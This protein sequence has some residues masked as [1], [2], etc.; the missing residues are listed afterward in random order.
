MDP[1]AALV[2]GAL[3]AFASTSVTGLIQW[4]RDQRKIRDGLSRSR[5]EEALKILSKLRSEALGERMTPG[6]RHKFDRDELD[7][8]TEAGYLVADESVRVCVIATTRVINSMGPAE[9]ELDD[10][11]HRIQRRMLHAAM[12]TVAAYLR[13]DDA[14]PQQHLK[15]VRDRAKIVDDEWKRAEEAGETTEG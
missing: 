8:L 2:L 13:M 11:V 1:L 7:R 12:E 6:D 9:H 14:L 5:A 10:Q 3:I 15:Y 4:G